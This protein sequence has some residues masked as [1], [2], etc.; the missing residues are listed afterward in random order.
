MMNIRLNSI[1][2]SF[3]KKEVIEDLTFEFSESSMTAIAGE[4]ASGKTTLLKIIVGLINQ[5]N[6]EVIYEKNKK[7]LS[8]DKAKRYLGMS[9]NN[10]FVI[11]DFSGLEYFQFIRKIYK[12]SKD[13]YNTVFQDL[14]DNLGINP[15]IFSYEISSY[16]TGYTKL[17][18][19][20]G[21]LLYQPEVILLDEPLNS[22][23]DK[24][25]ANL[26]DYLIHLKNRGKTIIIATHH[27]SFINDC[28]DKVLKL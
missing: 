26:Q 19:I 17:T 6:G 16:S 9:G 25:S 5:T 23:D 28:C 24:H 11:E 22:L 10:E 13:R 1:S 8:Y 15:E 2:K 3:S 27:E 20:M 12:I 14:L 7:T 21:M 18:E 4:N